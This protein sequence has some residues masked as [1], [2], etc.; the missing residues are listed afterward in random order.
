MTRLTREEWAQFNDHG[1]LIVR[2]LLRGEEL[3]VLQDEID[4]I[5]LGTADVQYADL[6]MEL[7]V[8]GERMPEYSRGFKGA[9][10][11]YKRIQHLELAPVVLRYLQKPVFR[12]ACERIYGSKAVSLF[13]AV[14]VNKLPGRGARIGWH[15]DCWNYLDANPV[16]TVWTA[17]D[18]ATAESGC[19]RV[20]SGSHKHGH[21]SKED[22]SGFLT[23]AM[24]SEHC[25]NREV[26]FLDM[27]PGDVVFLHNYI[28]HAS[29]INGSERRRRA[30]SVCYMDASTKNLREPVAYPVVFGTDAACAMTG[31]MLLRGF[32]CD[33]ASFGETVERVS[34]GL[35]AYLFR[36]TPRSTVKGLVYS[37]T[38]YPQDQ[39]IP[40]HNEMSY[41]I[42]WPRRLWMLCTR[43]ATTG[44]ATTVA[45]SVVV[46][47]KIPT[48]IR[49]RFERLG[50]QYR[51]RYGPHLDLSWQE[52]FQTDDRAE[53]DAECRR[54]G[55]RHEWL[56]DDE[57]VTSVV[58]PAS[59]TH[60]R[61]GDV[62]WFNQAHLFHPSALAPEVRQ[63]MHSALGE[64]RLPRA[65]YFGDGSPIPDEDVAAIHGAYAEAAIEVE[66]KA[67]DL[68]VVDNEWLAHGRR[69]FTGPRRV[70]VAMSQPTTG[71]R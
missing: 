50:V 32:A 23:K 53:V 24:V 55:L 40:L 30:L 60:P 47:S 5:M 52:G 69:P 20:L 38:E 31:D 27:N 63:A 54:Q 3:R 51:R 71:A 18:P 39:H 44:G 70:V 41:A 57:L 16:L 11:D 36:S 48:H 56:N 8:H 7:D 42:E 59:I 62:T 65:A 2:A 21:L 4:N 66:W 22:R 9:T 46:R 17:L 26:V 1:Y 10:L 68:L 67:S 13:R 33:E 61:S 37:S 45:D 28:L 25:R 58:R 12:D 49:E 15:Q 29:D 14:L 64:H 19:L 6:M 35:F 34:G 43:P